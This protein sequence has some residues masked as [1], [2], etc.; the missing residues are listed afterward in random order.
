MP[1]P[2]LRRHLRQA[3]GRWLFRL[4]PDRGEA[5]LHRRRIFILPTRS[6]LLYAAAL[7]V[8]LLGAIN[9]DLALGHALTFLL[10]GMGMAAMVHTFR[11]LEGLQLSSGAVAPVF[12]GEAARLPLQ[13]RHGRQDD[14]RAID[15]LVAGEIRAQGD[16]TAGNSAT[17][18]IPFPAPSRGRHPLPRLTLAC[19][20]PLG[21]FRAWAYYQPAQTHLVYPCPL[22]SPLPPARA[23]AG[24]SEQPGEGGQ[25]DFSGL[26][27]RQ[28]A[29]PLRHIAW[30]AAARD[31]GDRP[32]PVK[33]FSGGSAQELWL[34]WE[35]LPP[36]VGLEDGL[37]R[38]AAWVLAA[39]QQGLHYGL[40][41]P[42][43]AIAP[44]CGPAHQQRCLEALALYPGGSGEPQPEDDR[45]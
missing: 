29:D 20:Y 5:T 25:E 21:L 30:K 28:P 37:S 24:S 23:T 11:N 44:A 39:E 18:S 12:A 42:G 14:R 40:D 32:L 35:D 4:K 17:L 31:A 43:I 33:Q 6:G 45:P 1:L 2:A 38:L 41:L 22:S 34:A 15:V 26:R 19:V 36:R 7:V 16:V 10:A 27:P 8:M 3:L 13:L 9:Y